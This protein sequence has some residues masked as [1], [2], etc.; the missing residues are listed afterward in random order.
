VNTGAVARSVADV[1]LGKVLEATP[2]TI[3]AQS[4]LSADQLAALAGV[5]VNPV[6][7][8]PTF[9][10]VREGNLAL[11]R[12]AGPALVPL[13]ESRFRVTAAPMEIEFKPNGELTQ[14][15]LGWP[16]RRPVTLVR[17]TVA[18]PT[19]AELDRYAGKY[20]SEELDAT[21]TVVATDTT[22]ELRTR[23]GASRTVRPVYKDVFAGD[24]LLEFA[25]DGR[26]D[27][28]GMSMS[29]GRVRRVQFVRR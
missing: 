4:K 29:G 15:F 2:P 3:T 22:L 17:R 13:S 19:R 10:A 20:Y 28:R 18:T 5:Y 21:Y 23:M 25:R 24:F 26:G 12:T 1:Y 7:G 14:T 6:T 8:A 16:S 11:G 27:I 9:I